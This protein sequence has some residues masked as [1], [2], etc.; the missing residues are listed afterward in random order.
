MKYLDKK[1]TAKKLNIKI[2]ENE[3]RMFCLF[4]YEFREGLMG[5]DY[6][7]H[8]DDYDTFSDTCVSFMKKEIKLADI[9]FIKDR[10]WTFP[11]MWDMFRYLFKD[12]T[13]N[14]CHKF[15]VTIYRRW[16]DFQIGE[17]DEN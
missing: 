14:E 16:G 4:L 10:Y 8:N 13:F 1:P 7:F 11:Q 17:Y 15:A 12:S 3:F 2:D 6:V 5:D 9:V